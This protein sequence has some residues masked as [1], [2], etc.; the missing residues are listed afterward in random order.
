MSYLSVA[1]WE[2]FQHYKD[3]TPPWIKLHR[4]ILDDYEF[5]CLQDA[6]KAHL[7]LIWVLASQLE[8]KIPND[9]KWVKNKLGVVDDIDFNELIEKGFLVLASDASKPL[10]KC[11]LETEEDK[12]TDKEEEGTAVDLYNEVAKRIEIP[13]AQ[14]ISDTRKRNLRARL[15]DCGGLEGWRSALEKLEASEFCQGKNDKGWK[16]DFDFLVRES[17]FIKLM[18]GKYDGQ[19]GRHSQSKHQRACEAVLA[20]ITEGNSS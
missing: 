18:E 7:M 4:E 13:I 17:S 8:N 6:S 15:K 14:K 11:S 16:A 3:R 10:A 12:E 9:P 2:Q 5:S 1:N 19:T 20:G